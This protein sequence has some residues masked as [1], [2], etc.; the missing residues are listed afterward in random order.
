M[1][2]SFVVLNA[3]EAD[4]FLFETDD[5]F[6]IYVA[7]GDEDNIG[8]HV[9]AVAVVMR[10]LGIYAEDMENTF[11]GEYTALYPDN[12][13]VTNYLKGEG[14]IEDPSLAEEGG[15]CI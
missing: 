14:W 8:C 6:V 4:P 9:P 11:S 10:G 12:D 3:R 1:T 2:Y 13:S 5:M 7:R 15:L